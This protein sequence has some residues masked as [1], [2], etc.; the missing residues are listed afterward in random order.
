MSTIATRA[1]WC[2]T[3]TAVFLA[4]KTVLVYKIEA[5]T[6]PTT[7]ISAT[8]TINSTS[9]KP[10][11]PSEDSNRNRFLKLRVPVCGVLSTFIYSRLSSA[12]AHSGAD[13]EGERELTA[14]A[15]ASCIVIARHQGLTCGYVHA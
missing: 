7:L 4:P 13:R 2:A 10:S 12:Y 9:L 11:I 15:N 1:C 3:L 14:L 8:V 5:K 6:T